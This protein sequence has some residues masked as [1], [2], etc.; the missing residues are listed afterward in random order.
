MKRSKRICLFL[1]VISNSLFAYW[2]QEVNYKIDVKLNDEKHQLDA[3]I[4]FEYVNNSNDTLTFLYIHLWPNAY[5]NTQT[6]LA[7]QV[8]SNGEVEL[9]YATSAEKGKIDSLDFKVNNVSAKWTYYNKQIDIAKLELNQPLLPHQSIKVSTPFRVKI[10]SGKISRLGHIDQTYQITQWYPKPAVYDANGWNPMTYLDQGEFYSEYGSFDVKI[11]LPENYIVGA[12]G[13]LQGESAQQETE[14]L[15]YRINDT[16]DKLKKAKEGYWYD[17]FNRR[18]D[19]TATA[20]SKHFK[21][22]EYHQENVHDFAWFANKEWN[23]LQ[24]EVLLPRSNRKVKTWIMFTDAQSKLWQHAL[25]Y[26]HDA[27]YNYSLWNGEYPYKHV[28]AVD[29]ALSAGSGM[30]YPN[31]TVIGE[32]SSSMSLEEVIMHEIGHNWFYGILG[33]NERRYAWMDEGINSFNEMRYMMQKFPNKK[34]SDFIFSEA[35]IILRQNDAPMSEVYHQMYLYNTVKGLDQPLN[36]TS[37]QY[38]D[39]NYGSIVYSKSAVI[40]YYLFNYLGAEEFDYCMKMYYNQWKFK[41]PQPHDFE[42]IFKA[43]TKK[44]LDWFFKDLINTTKFIDYDILCT[45]NKNDSIYIT[46]K[47][48]GEVSSPVLISCQLEDKTIAEYW[49]EGFKGTQKLKIPAGSFDEII[50]DAKHCIPEINRSNNI[51]RTK[52]ILRTSEPLRFMLVSSMENPKYNN[53][54]FIPAIAYNYNDKFMFGGIFHN[55]QFPTKNLRFELAPLYSTQS[56]KLTGYGDISYFFRKPLPFLSSAEIGVKGRQY[57]SREYKNIHAQFQ[58]W[59]TYIHLTFKKVNARSPY[60]NEIHLRQI[61]TNNQLIVG[62]GLQDTCMKYFEAKHTLTRKHALNSFVVNSIFQNGPD[63]SKIAIDADFKFRINKKGQFFKLR[64][65]GGYF[66]DPTEIIN[67][68]FTLRGH[69]D[70]DYLF[71]ET[72]LARNQ[73]NKGNFLTQ[74][75]YMADGGF[76]TGLFSQFIYAKEWMTTLNASIDLPLKFLSVYGDLGSSDGII[77]NSDKKY[78]YDAGIRLSVYKDIA[79]VFFP[80]LMSEEI[81]NPY[82]QDGYAY[83]QRIRFTINFSKI[84][85]LYQIKKM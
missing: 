11:T 66:I 25:E 56:K 54:Y 59:E 55:T 41:H 73:Y 24:G 18:N 85:L 77:N 30:E 52:G 28:T 22:L 17:V 80:V 83:L 43:N 42:A 58:K 63:F 20:S 35:K 13:D 68:Q 82:D 39:F 23:V 34:I 74:Q 40:L 76:K 9:N 72:F 50:I 10:P 47:N 53:L 57:Q 21:T 1:L 81:R 70:E 4:E 71:D 60:L 46:V 48:F 26:V 12:T 45:E 16:K 62:E 6:A 75:F 14:W 65:F 31:I 84:N 2:Q 27:T 8:L 5:K 67:Q 36:L 51:I 19:T 38:T 32:T 64:F 15:N 29:G 37:A 69:R 79:Q 3:F 49:F 7:K 44:N 78:M 33:S 61:N